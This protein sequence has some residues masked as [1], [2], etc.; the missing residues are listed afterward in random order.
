MAKREPISKKL[1]FEVFKRDSF[2]CQY[3]GRK[4]PQVVLVAD[5]VTPVKE[6]GPTTILNLVASCFECNAGK[7]GVSLSDDSV[8]QKQ[9]SELARMQ[10]RREQIEMMLK[11][12]EELKSQ[13]E[14]E[15]S[16]A[17]A[18]IESLTELL[19][20]DIGKGIVRRWFSRYSL[21]EILEAI[22]RSV[23]FYFLQQLNKEGQPTKKCLESFNNMIAMVPRIAKNERVLRKNPELKVAYHARNILRKNLRVYPNQEQ[24]ALEIILG[25]I[26]GGVPEDQVF[27]MCATCR[28]WTDLERQIENYLDS[29][30]E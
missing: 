22:T 1:R 20:N 11:W 2:T 17:V 30:A 8:L 4:A 14:L 3:C 9:H 10:E 28:N 25:A 7:G 27:R 13:S 23:N 6:G 24:Q 26:R 29:S 19:L 21:E 18:E 12:R 5:H 16:L 15:V